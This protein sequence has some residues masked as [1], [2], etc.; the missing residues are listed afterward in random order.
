MCGR[1]FDPRFLFTWPT[2]RVCLI[3][4]EQ[5]AGVL[6]DLR[7]AQLKRAGEDPS[8]EEIAEIRDPIF[9]RYEADSSPYYAT[10]EVWDDGMIDPADT[11][12]ALG[13]AISASLNAPMAE[14][15]NGIL[16]L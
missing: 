15:R 10:S 7:V 11:R 12:N 3:G 13:L 2:A 4:A 5:A 9:Q 16:R 6:T 14:P 1:A 8:D